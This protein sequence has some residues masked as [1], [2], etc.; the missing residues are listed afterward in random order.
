[1][2]DIIQG[3]RLTIARHDR[4][5]KKAREWLVYLYSGTADN[6]GREAFHCWLNQSPAH[7]KAYRAL[8]QIW[9]DLVL[10]DNIEEVASIPGQRPATANSRAFSVFGLTPAQFR[11]LRSAIVGGLIAASLMVVI[12]TL[13]YQFYAPVKTTYYST[14]IGKK[15][16]IG[17]PDGSVVTLGADS[18]IVTRFS[19]HHREV[20]LTRGDAYF[21]VAH[22]AARVFK[23]TVSN[24]EIRVFGTE[25]D[26]KKGPHDVRVAV[27]RGKVEVSTARGQQRGTRPPVRLYAG[28][29]V[30]AQLN[31]TLAQKTGFNPATVFSWRKGRLVYVNVPLAEVI[32][33]VNRYRKIPIRIGTKSLETIRVT[34]SFRSGNSDQMLAGLAAT[35]SVT[36][37]NMGSFI[38][39]LPKAAVKKS[40]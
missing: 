18:A 13:F 25:F 6:R 4:I 7:L 17:L 31:G 29:Q 33:D 10:I 12:G 5:E 1:M 35:E 16:N 26:V 32:A 36:I 21:D 22:D 14:G 28:E 19:S 30:I 23:I 3:D 24:T 27:A 8:E 37:T 15:D 20:A 9:R 39:I 34:T 40:L 11:N 38:M 2:N